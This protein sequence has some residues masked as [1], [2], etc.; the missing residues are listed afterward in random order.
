MK[1]AADPAS[2]VNMCYGSKD[3]MASVVPDAR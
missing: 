1:E 2:K 3:E